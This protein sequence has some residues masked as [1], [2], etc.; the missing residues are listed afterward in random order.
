MNDPRF[1]GIEIGGT[2]LQVVLGDSHGMILQKAQTRANSA[3]GATAILRQLEEM[4]HRMLA[5]HVDSLVGIGI[6]FG[7]PVDASKGMVVKS[8][9]VEGWDGFPLQD[10]AETNF[11]SPCA[12]GND[13]D[14]AA[15]AEARVDSRSLD[16]C[17]FYTNIGSGIGGGL[18]VDGKLYS[19]P[20]GAMEFGHTRVFSMMHRRTGI[21]EDFCSGWSLDQRAQEAA[22]RDADSALWEHADE[23]ARNI[24]TRRM[25][26][27][28]QLGDTA[29]SQ[30]VDDFFDCYTRALSNVVAL[31]NPDVVVIGGGLAQVGQPLLQTIR[32]RIEPLIYAPFKGSYRIEL[33]EYGEQA[34]TVG[35]VLLA[36]QS[37]VCR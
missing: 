15:V 8:N 37:F 2:K 12:I 6:G 30:V 16:R 34:V 26:K 29:A 33:S 27:A 7:G 19:R 10:W 25:F 3:G 1:L 14:V 36:A 28:W 21:L 5:S 11:D 24:D 4:V 9:H 23:E 31:L 35:A 17:V 18:V 32:E 22:E 13:T 20:A